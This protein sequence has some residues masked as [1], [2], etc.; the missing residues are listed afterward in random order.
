MAAAGVIGVHE[1]DVSKLDF[2]TFR[3]NSNGKGGSVPYMYDGQPVLRLQTPVGMRLPFG[4]STFP[5]SDPPKKNVD[6]DLEG[7]EAFQ[8]VIESVEAAAREHAVANHKSIL[9]N[10]N[11]EEAAMIAKYNFRSNIKKGKGQYS[12][13]FKA[14]VDYSERDG[15]KIRVFVGDMESSAL[16][17][18]ADV[19]KNSTATA[20]VELRSFWVVDGKF[21]CKWTCPQIKVYNKNKKLHET[22]EMVINDGSVMA[23]PDAAAAQLEAPHADTDEP[24]AKRQRVMPALD[25]PSDEEPM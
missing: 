20:I 24:E 13:T 14:A 3:P 15:D 12:D 21:G 1:F 19:P 6:F 9:K 8:A 7:H 17:T 10:D 25:A 5:D 23:A 11:R 16:G 18:C 2:G 22:D 4:I